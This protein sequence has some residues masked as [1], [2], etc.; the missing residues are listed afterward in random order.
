MGEKKETKGRRLKSLRSH[1]ISEYNTQSQSQT[2]GSVIWH[3]SKIKC[4][5]AYIKDYFH[6]SRKPSRIFKIKDK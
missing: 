1:E 2:T 3:T 5:M 6:F 4:D